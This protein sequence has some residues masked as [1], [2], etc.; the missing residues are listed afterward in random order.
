VQ[1]L[2]EP[3]GRVRCLYGEEIDLSRLG[4]LSIERASRVEPDAAGAWWADLSPVDGPVLGPFP[5]RSDA[6]REEV[7]WLLANWLVRPAAP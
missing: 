5:Q 3:G 6:L 1:L 4:R 7:A 2:I